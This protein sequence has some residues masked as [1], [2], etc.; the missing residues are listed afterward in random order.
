MKRQADAVP[1]TSDLVADVSRIKLYRKIGRRI[2]P[3][4][5]VGL[6]V[7]YLDRLNIS[8][9]KTQMQADF[10]MS[11]AVYGLGAGIFFLGY[12]LF[13]VPS[14]LILV[15]VGARMWL[16]RIMFSWG[17]ISALMMFVENAWHFYVMR[18]LLG[19][20]EAGFIPGVLLYLTGW[21]P[22]EW[23][24]RT[25]AKFLAGTVL[26]GILG[27]PIAAAILGPT[28]GLAGLHGWQWLF[29]IEGLAA[30][31]L[32]FVL[33]ASLQ[34]S[35]DRVAWLTEVEKEAVRSDLRAEGSQTSTHA[36]V[37]VA[38]RDPRTVHLVALFFFSVFSVGGVSFW[39]PQ[40][41]A[42][43]GVASPT[44]VVLLSAVPYT[45]AIGIQLWIA[46]SSDRRGDR[47]WHIVGASVLGSCGWAL[48][49]LGS[50]IVTALAGLSMALTGAVAATLV[51]TIPPSYLHGAAVAG[52][53]ALIHAMGNLGTFASP[54]AVGVLSTA[55]GTL[56]VA[57]AV[58]A[59]SPLLCAL[60]A[61]F[62][63]PSLARVP[64]TA[65]GH[66]A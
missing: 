5:F 22:A 2:L 33:L 19:V 43:S 40:V 30:V 7:A 23:R 13:E 10:A 56:T 65:A 42:Q 3:I 62:L 17:V 58:L 63:P 20:A 37:L 49:L 15:R 53:L 64:R 28:D 21:F 52:G 34:S 54:Y 39:A 44:G 11:D 51:L 45:V 31:V 25:T 26:A 41:I 29:L 57:L 16:F 12:M 4:L 27:G 9:A 8:Y 59:A 14:N 24:A 32:S 38:V 48:T 55:T 35:P 46:R 47:K 36:H 60:L 18:F 66:L 6:V 61:L 50:N 1:V